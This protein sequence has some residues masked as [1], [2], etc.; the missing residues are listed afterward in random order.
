M[1]LRSGYWRQRKLTVQPPEPKPKENGP[2][3]ALQ[4][5]AASRHAM[6]TLFTLLPVAALSGLLQGCY[7][8][9]QP[10]VP[11][12]TVSQADARV[13]F[14]D[15]VLNRR[16]IFLLASI[17]VRRHAHSFCRPGTGVRHCG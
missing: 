12:K 7:T 8:P 15:P 2:N 16:Q 17:S 10:S 6:R 4:R 1:S 14:S 9:H 5:A 13:D 11:E 3:H